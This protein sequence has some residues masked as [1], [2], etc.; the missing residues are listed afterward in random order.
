MVI[1]HGFDMIDEI[2]QKILHILQ[3]K[4]RI[5]N[6]EVARQVGLTP[7][8]VLERIRKLEKSGIIDGYEVKL[9][10]GLFDRNFL[11]FVWVYPEKNEG[12]ELPDALS[13]IPEIQEIHYIS[14]EDCY[15]IKI[16]TSGP[17]ALKD[18][19]QERIRKIEGVGSTKSQVVLS[20]YKETSRIPLDAIKD[21]KNN[22]DQE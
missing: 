3:E 22:V 16:R 1:W 15:F 6:V 7:S 11:S 19:I 9:N 10:P 14:G 12:P 13:R 18:I 20:T 4:A 21:I 8:A 5:P 17:E 2:S